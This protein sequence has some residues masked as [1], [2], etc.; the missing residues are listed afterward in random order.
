[1]AT[2]DRENRTGGKSPLSGKRHSEFGWAEDMRGKHHNHAKRQQ[3]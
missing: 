3:E 2:K 1:M